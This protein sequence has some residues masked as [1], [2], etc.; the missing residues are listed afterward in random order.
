MRDEPGV[1]TG[2]QQ[3]GG[4]H[5][6]RRAASAGRA[7]SGRSAG[8]PPTAPSRRPARPAG[9]GDDHQLGARG[10]SAG[11]RAGDAGYRP[12]TGLTPIRSLAACRPEHSRSRPAGRRADQPAGGCRLSRTWSTQRRTPSAA[13]AFGSNTG[14]NPQPGRGDSRRRKA[15]KASSTVWCSLPAS[16]PGRPGQGSPRLGQRLDGQAG[17]PEVGAVPGPGGR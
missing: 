16:T 3:A 12:W 6:R 1:A 13:A 11:D 17:D 4:D 15:A 9:R 10:E 14:R 8:A 2:V 5:R 7:R